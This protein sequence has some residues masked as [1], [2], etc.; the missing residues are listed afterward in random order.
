[1]GVSSITS[2]A[3]IR[4]EDVVMK[5]LRALAGAKTACSHVPESTATPSGDRCEECGSGHSLR[6][7]A[8]C[9]HVGC[10]ESQRGDARR[11]SQ[12]AGHAVIIAMPV[13]RG[14]T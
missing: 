5:L 13:E 10:C 7:C 6:M 1:V 2:P 12:E 4:H 14:F 9:G 3:A 8:T 11:H